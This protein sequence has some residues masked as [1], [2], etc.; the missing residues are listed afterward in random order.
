M[1]RAFLKFPENGPRSRLQTLMLE[2]VEA[3]EA[4]EVKYC[5]L[6][7]YSEFPA[8]RSVTSDFDILIDPLRWHDAEI[9]IHRAIC[10]NNAYVVQRIRRSGRMSSIYLS[11]RGGPAL[12]IDFL[13]QLSWHQYVWAHAGIVLN[14]AQKQKNCYV[15]RPGH[16]AAVSLIT[17]LFH[18]GTVKEEYKSKIH[19]M[20]LSDK[21]GFSEI[22]SQFQEDSAV[23]A[24][25]QSILRNDWPAV[26]NWANHAKRKLRSNAWHRSPLKNLRNLAGQLGN[27]VSRFVNPPGL[28]V[29][30]I[31]PDGCGKTTIAHSLIEALSS[32]FPSEK[33]SYFHWRPGLLP[34]PA[35]LWHSLRHGVKK[36]GPSAAADPHG[37][38]PYSQI[39]SFG[40][41]FY[42]WLD[43][44]LGIPL[45]IRPR[46]ARN[47]LIIIDRYYYDF[48]V[49]PLRYRLK[50]PGWAGKLGGILLPKPDMVFYLDVPI[51][52]LN[53]RKQ[54]LPEMELL[55]QQ[56]L[57]KKIL[58]NCGQVAHCINANKPLLD[59]VEQIRSDVYCFL[60]ARGN[61]NQRTDVKVF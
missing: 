38:L 44:L 16:E 1:Q 58:P 23:D 42:F 53:E 13:S 39:I 9:L 50:L 32:I 8:T 33:A 31:G 57:F 48:Q 19:S 10:E 12:R 37:Q 49:D 46:L 34:S 40:R 47:G 18:R 59:V 25:I 2:F 7:N 4:N 55:R 51:E 61:F 6:R 17:Y 52:V 26:V 15:P 43:Y 22:I 24:L 41:F 45:R 11:G 20:L 30:L 3:L 29:V 28:F 21:A 35:S 60:A 5:I 54:E 14:S 56:Q 36:D 27:Y